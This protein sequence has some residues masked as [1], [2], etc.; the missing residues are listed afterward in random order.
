MGIL[1][2]KIVDLPI[3]NIY[4]WW[5]FPVRK[6]QQIT[7]GY[8][9]S[10]TQVLYINK[11]LW[12]YSLW[13]FNIHWH[14]QVTFKLAKQN[15]HIGHWIV[16]IFPEMAIDRPT[17]RHPNLEH[18]GA[19]SPRLSVPRWRA[20]VPVD[21]HPPDLG[22]WPGWNW[23]RNESSKSCLKKWWKKQ[24]LNNETVIYYN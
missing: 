17:S 21:D 11:H 13:L 2:E 16:G 22:P 1:P 18:P 10:Y 14:I 23:M 12:E 3:T 6:L 24:W 15:G 7:R 19:R 8:V 5:I 20:H 9:S 4:K